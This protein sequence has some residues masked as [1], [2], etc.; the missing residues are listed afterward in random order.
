MLRTGVEAPI[1]EPPSAAKTLVRV[2][3]VEFMPAFVQETVP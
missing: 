2:L 3:S 1:T